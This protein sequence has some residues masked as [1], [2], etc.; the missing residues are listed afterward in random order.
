MIKYKTKVQLVPIHFRLRF[1]GKQHTERFWVTLY[2]VG[3]KPD[4]FG[5]FVTPVY[6][7]IE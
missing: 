2:R 4:C 1:H 5:K 6:V 3:Q 7:V